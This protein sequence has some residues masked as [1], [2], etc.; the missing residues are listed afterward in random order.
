MTVGVLLL[1]AGSSRR[2]GADKRL[3]AFADGQTVLERTLTNIA[4][5]D[6]PCRV[7]LSSVDMAMTVTMPRGDIE[8]IYCS[9]AQLGMGATLA[10]GM[11][12]LS[13]WTGVL[14]AL[15]DMPWLLPQTYRSIA[16][17]TTPSTI[18][19]PVHGGRRGNPVGFGK[20]FFPE[21]RQCRGDTGARDLIERRST[22]IRA[23]EVAD[24]G[25]LRDIDEPADLPD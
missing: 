3:A 14:I 12:D 18:C 19:T 9:D 1:A 8:I 24:S 6:L 15:A 22:A 17:H 21:L 16:C 5:A 25:V 13:A 7:C 23:L 10:E 20:H 11:K 4:A 2:F